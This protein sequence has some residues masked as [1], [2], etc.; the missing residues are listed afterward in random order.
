MQHAALEKALKQLAASERWAWP[1]LCNDQNPAAG[2][3]QK[4]TLLQCVRLTTSLR[5]VDTPRQAATALDAIRRILG[6]EATIARRLMEVLSVEAGCILTT[7]Q[8]AAEQGIAVVADLLTEIVKLEELRSGKKSQGDHVRGLGVLT[9]PVLLECI[10]AGTTRSWECNWEAIQPQLQPI[11]DLAL[12][13]PLLR[14]CPKSFLDLVCKNVP[15][16]L[17]ELLDVD[18]E[19]QSHRLNSA[20]PEPRCLYSLGCLAQE[21]R[22]CLHQRGELGEHTKEMIHMI[23]LQGRVLQ[24]LK[25]DAVEVAH[26]D[27]PVASTTATNVKKRPAA[28]LSC[29]SPT[30]ESRPAKVQKTPSPKPK[31][32]VDETPARLSQGK[33]RSQMLPEPAKVSRKSLTKADTSRA[34]DQVNAAAGGEVEVKKLLMQVLQNLKQHDRLVRDFTDKAAE[35]VSTISKFC[36]AEASHK[37]RSCAVAEDAAKKLSEFARYLKTITELD[38][39]G[40]RAVAAQMGRYVSFL[41]QGSGW[42]EEWR[43]ALGRMLELVT[44]PLLA[45]PAASELWEQATGSNVSTIRTTPKMVLA[46]GGLTMELMQ[47]LEEDTSE[48]AA[49]MKS[50]MSQ[51]RF[52]CEWSQ[53]ATLSA[54]DVG[55]MKSASTSM[56]R[57]K[58]ACPSR[59]AYQKVDLKSSTDAPS[60]TSS[61][62]PAR[63]VDEDSEGELSE[64]IDSED[65]SDAD[66]PEEDA[67]LEDFIDMSPEHNLGI[68]RE[69]ISTAFDTEPCSSGLNGE[70]PLSNVQRFLRM[71]LAPDWQDRL[72]SEMLKHPDPF[73][74]NADEVEAAT[75]PSSSKE[76][77]KVPEKLVQ[78]VHTK[79]SLGKES[80]DFPPKPPRL[81][82]SLVV[83]AA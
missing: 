56:D 14:Y 64:D 74:P 70:R 29:Q 17:P 71:S 80:E 72:R 12:A 48:E 18:E 34:D 20:S 43:G 31:K 53:G 33:G 76:K 82:A 46:V 62:A 16:L 3:S 30:K 25:S 60:S 51:L 22:D 58:K 66:E 11:H 26:S 23:R 9:L 61:R 63:T 32:V 50:L 28:M 41:L 19:S 47:A 21:I 57:P 1:E 15:H 69:E 27:A 73:E 83:C 5:A 6:P 75:C 7:G 81:E 10:L 37:P 45:L 79:D 38:S 55:M 4:A 42:S 59:P 78:P 49:K 68:L 44:H 24:H 35:A 40:K 52:A 77:P 2:A 54:K 67:E 13:P 39:A 8:A 65:S 36:L